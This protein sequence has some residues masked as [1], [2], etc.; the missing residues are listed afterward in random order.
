MQITRQIDFTPKSVSTSGEKEI[1]SGPPEVI[2]LADESYGS[3]GSDDPGPELVSV[4]GVRQVGV[5]N[6]C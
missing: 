3:A 5:E 4:T 2:H 1:A 6:V